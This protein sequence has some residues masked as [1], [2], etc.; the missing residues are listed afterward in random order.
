MLPEFVDFESKIEPMRVMDRL[1]GQVRG[2]RVAFFFFGPLEKLV[3]LCLRERNRQAPG[4]GTIVIKNVG[5]TWC[6]QDAKP[7][8]CDGP[9]CVLAAGTTT[10]V[11]ASQHD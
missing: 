8:V 1:A 9:R 5:I 7:V 6:D 3:Y 2:H 11:R 10:E 4:L